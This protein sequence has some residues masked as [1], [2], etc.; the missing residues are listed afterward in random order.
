MIKALI[1]ISI[2]ISSLSYAQTNI[3]ELER[4]NGVWIKKNTKEKFTGTFIEYFPD[5][6]K[7]GT[8]ELKDGVPDGRRIVYFE[9]GNTSQ[10]KLLKKGVYEGTNI[11]Y[12]EN[13][14]VKQEGQM[15]AGKSDGIWKIYYENGNVQAVLTFENGVEKGDY[16]QYDET[17]K[18]VAQYYILDGKETYSKEFLNLNGK[19]LDLQQKG[20]FK[21]A[22][23]LYD[24]AIQSNPTVAK[25]YYNRGACKSNS[26]DFE[27]AISDYD[28]AIGLDAEYKEAYRNRGIA[29]INLLNAAKANAG[30]K[31]TPEQT[32]S[33]CEDFNKAAQLGDKSADNEDMI[34]L[35]CKKKGNR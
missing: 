17:G 22:I 14:N 15:K 29:K 19:A 5:G 32:K 16:F 31:L 25:T 28:K 23:A 33:A 3:N 6:K 34:F 21:E 11:E 35:Y 9:N 4:S 13:G 12:F 26:F 24:S 8:C 18:L 30:E 27:G 20:K 7:M 10:D 1:G 2:L